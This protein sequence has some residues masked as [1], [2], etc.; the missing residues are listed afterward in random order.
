MTQ[1]TTQNVPSQFIGF[2]DD[3]A[4]FPP[5]LA[6]LNKAIIDHVARRVSRFNDAVGPAV[7]A[8]KDLPEAQAIASWLDLGGQPVEV[9]AVVPPGGLEAALEIAEQVGPEIHVAALELKTNPADKALW[10]AQITQA[11]QVSALPIYVELDAGQV[12]A[13]ALEMLARHSLHLKYRTGGIKA[14]L[15]PSPAQLAPV[16]LAAV[17]AG[18]TF[19]LTAGLHE[20]VRYTN[21]DTGF[22]HHGFLNI[23]MATQAARQGEEL[24]AITALLSETNPDPL[25][26]LAQ[27]GDAAWRRSFSSFGTCSVGEPAE[28]LKRLGLFPGALA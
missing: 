27:T 14:E 4:T 5:G 17:E 12:E 7:L 26:Q 25:V 8:L 22:T 10:S 11:A 9:S 15:F 1:T 19:K 21:P 18:I 13:G 3:A 6:P 2:F 28:S 16:L 20:A 23:A 24:H